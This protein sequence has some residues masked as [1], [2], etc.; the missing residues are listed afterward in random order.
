MIKQLLSWLN[1]LWR[2]VGMVLVFAV[3]GF[4]AC[5]FGY[6]FLPLWHFFQK[7]KT[8][9]K[10][11][12][13]KLISYL[14]RCLIT[15]IQKLKLINVEFK[16]FY[17]LNGEKGCLFLANHPTFLDYIAII[18]RLP[19]CD[20]IVKEALWKNPAAKRTIT[21]AGYIP[22][23]SGEGILS[24]IK[25]TLEEG[26]NLLLFPEGTRTNPNKPFTLK[27]G[28][29]QIAVRL[30]VPIRLIHVTC[31]PPVLTKHA[32]WYKIP[33]VKP[34]LTLSVGHRIDADTFLS[35]ETPPSLAARQL[36]RHLE[37][38]LAKG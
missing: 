15:S 18:S 1:Y 16:N 32:K 36:T 17:L 35:E 26:N 11:K 29:A 5:L 3:G 10:V 30:N 6:V 21:L 37:E 38:H 14:F 23:A 20:N 9:V 24:H 13:Q 12:V 31:T 27:R 7:D 19:R 33:K 28:A 34:T 8:Q 2:L 22:N 25:N 4:I